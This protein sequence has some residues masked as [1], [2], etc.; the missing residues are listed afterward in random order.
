MK[1][2]HLL[3]G[4]IALIVLVG[5]VVPAEAQYHRHHRRHHRHHRVYRRR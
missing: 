2:R 1:I 4:A 3:L 5:S